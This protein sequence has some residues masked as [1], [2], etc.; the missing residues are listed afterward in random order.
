MKLLKNLL[1]LVSIITATVVFT[2]CSSGHFRTIWA[3]DIGDITAVNNYVKKNSSTLSEVLSQM[4][5]PNIA[6]RD[7]SNFIVSRKVFSSTIENT[8]NKVVIVQYSADSNY[9]KDQFRTIK[10][11]VFLLD[12][13]KLDINSIIKDVKYFGAAY[14]ISGEDK[15]YVMSDKELTIYT[16]MSSA[17]VN[18]RYKTGHFKTFPNVTE[19]DIIKDQISDLYGQ[20]GEIKE[21]DELNSLGRES[22]DNEDIYPYIHITRQSTANVLFQ[23]ILQVAGEYELRK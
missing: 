15:Y 8:N 22:L 19:N 13:D 18:G 6:K 21:E 9:M 1:A 3:E 23:S 5:D 12:G 17:Y 16:N 11:V 14:L 4:S 20:I 2:G 10:D 7:Y